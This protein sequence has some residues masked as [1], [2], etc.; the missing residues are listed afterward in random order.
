MHIPIVLNFNG[1][2]TGHKDVKSKAHRKEASQDRHPAT[3]VLR[4]PTKAEALGACRFKVLLLRR[5]AKPNDPVQTLVKSSEDNRILSP[6]NW[7]YYN[8]LADSLVTSGP[9][10]FQLQKPRG[11]TTEVV[12]CLWFQ[13]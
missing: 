13:L 10:H 1:R 4:T 5:A 11:R 8:H 6:D 3:C 9:L 12:T 7:P 2:G